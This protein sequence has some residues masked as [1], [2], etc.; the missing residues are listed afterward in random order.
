MLSIFTELYPHVMISA[1]DPAYSLTIGD[2]AS[3]SY[4]LTVMTVVVAIFLPVALAC[5]AWTCYVFRK[6]LSARDFEPPGPPG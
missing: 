3:G 4:S 1:T 6:R 5:T 2:S